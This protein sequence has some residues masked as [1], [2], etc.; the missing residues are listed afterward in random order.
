MKAARI[1]TFVK[2]YRDVDSGPESGLQPTMLPLHFSGFLE[3]K[4]AHTWCLDQYLVPDDLSL[5]L[6]FWIRSSG[7]QPHALDDSNFLIS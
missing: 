7:F 4:F 6:V 5:V 1:T 3:N 2:Q